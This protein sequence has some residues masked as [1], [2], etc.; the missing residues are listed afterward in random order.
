[1]GK[2]VDMKKAMRIGLEQGKKIRPVYGNRRA[3]LAE[4]DTVR[5]CLIRMANSDDAGLKGAL[6]GEWEV[7]GME[8]Q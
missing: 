8:Q 2:K 5:N 7:E 1:M 4:F 6:I 3:F